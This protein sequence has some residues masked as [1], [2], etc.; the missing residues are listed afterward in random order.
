[1]QYLEM[2]G[3]LGIGRGSNVIVLSP[4]AGVYIGGGGSFGSAGPGR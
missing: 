3:A 1:M 2:Y 4:V